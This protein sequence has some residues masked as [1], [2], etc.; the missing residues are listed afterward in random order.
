MERQSTASDSVSVRGRSLSNV[1]YDHEPSYSIVIAPQ[2]AT[3]L[4]TLFSHLLY[5]LEDI[6]AKLQDRG[7]KLASSLVKTEHF[8]IFL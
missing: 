4:S 7:S 2:I 5:I 1:A 8:E 6:M 3:L